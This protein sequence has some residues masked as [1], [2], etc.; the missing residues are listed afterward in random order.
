MNE[1]FVTVNGTVGSDVQLSSGERSNRSRFRLATAERYL[2]RATGEWVDRETVWL[3]VVCWR[4]L[5]DHVAVSV[6]KGQPVI[7]RGRLRVTHWES[8][9]G[10]RQ[11]LEVIATSVGHD[12]SMGQASFVRT[13]RPEAPQQ[14]ASDPP[15]EAPA[16]EVA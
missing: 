2:D 8:D 1:I 13:P 4:R 3:D 11:G 5:A 12:L 10:P 6:R 14:E 7:V 15:H 16:A 9:K